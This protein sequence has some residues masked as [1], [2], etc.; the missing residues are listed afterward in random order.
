MAMDIGTL[1][2]YL[3]LDTSKFEE[4]E[5][6]AG[7]KMPGWMA[8]AGALAA[9]AAAAA[10]GA[11][12]VN[13]VNVEA[14]NQK[15]AAQLGLTEEES[16]RAGDAAAGAYKAGFGESTAGVQETT[17]G[18]ISS[19][20]G[21]REASVDELEGIVSGVQMLSDSFGIEADRIYSVNSSRSSGVTT[22]MQC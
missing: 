17:A 3:D 12:F 21:M 15:V 16:R 20:R 22:P 18:V 4:G 10:F 14:G 13:A 11:A 8:A 1:V 2:G 19:I 9:T 5:K 7:A 6:G